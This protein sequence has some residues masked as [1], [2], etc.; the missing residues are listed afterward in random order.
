M[1][2]LVIR[3]CLGGLIV[4][5]FALISD[6]FKPK[7]FAGLFGAAPS[8]ALASLSIVVREESRNT[9]ATEA[10]SMMVGAVALFVYA[11][12]VSWLVMRFKMP[13]A[14]VALPGLLLWLGV[15]AGLWYAVI[16]S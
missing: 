5:A 9:A 7:T 14:K 6:I 12:F 16:G 15:A 10:G 3:F 8:V 4:S 13:A 2:Q 11:W 1:T